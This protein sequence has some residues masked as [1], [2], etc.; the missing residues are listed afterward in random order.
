[1]LGIVKKL[2]NRFVLIR[3]LGL[4][5]S[6]NGALGQ[7]GW[8]EVNF[9]TLR[10]SGKSSLPWFVYGAIDYLEHS[11]DPRAKVLELGGGHPPPSG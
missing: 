8:K 10:I 1:M 11:V 6:R 4:F 9:K 7:L 3:F 5:R 2:L